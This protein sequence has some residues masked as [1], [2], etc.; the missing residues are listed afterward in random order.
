MKTYVPTQQE[1]ADKKWY[2]IDANDVILGK[3]AVKAVNI[4][5]GK[6]KV[7]F[8]AH[9]DC[10][11][12]LIVI[13]AATIKTTGN[14]ENQKMYYRH[15]GWKGGLKSR[16]LGQLRT[17]NPIRIIHDAI[18]GMIPHN[19]LKKNLLGRLKIYAGNQ[20]PHSAQTPITIT[21]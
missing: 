1:T 5:R 14:K 4:L 21:I 19:K 17:E 3:M 13:N 16:T 12:F 9:L 15:S 20:H 6:N 11:D 10:G 18:A 7:D 8:T 2:L